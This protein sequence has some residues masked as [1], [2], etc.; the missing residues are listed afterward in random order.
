MSSS[1]VLKIPGDPSDT[2]RILARR[3]FRLQGPARVS[4]GF[5]RGISEAVSENIPLRRISGVQNRLVEANA[6]AGYPTDVDLV[7]KARGG[8]TVAVLR[9]EAAMAAM[10]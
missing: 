2:L 10:V 9:R 3:S 6:A 8:C 5:T 1:S 7:V 4:K